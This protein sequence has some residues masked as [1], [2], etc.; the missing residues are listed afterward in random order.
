MVYIL[1]IISLADFRHLGL[2]CGGNAAWWLGSSAC[3][4]CMAPIIGKTGK[5]RALRRFHGKDHGA[6]SGEAARQSCLPKMHGG[7][8]A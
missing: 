6:G 8:P 4:K 5:T 7:G 3:L 1:E 2:L